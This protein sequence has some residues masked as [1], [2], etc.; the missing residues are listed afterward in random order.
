MEVLDEV[1]S[2]DFYESGGGYRYY[3]AEL[4][5]GLFFTRGTVCGETNIVKGTDFRP[6]SQTGMARHKEQL[7]LLLFNPGKRIPGIPFIG[8]RIDIFDPE[9]ARLYDFRIDLDD[10]E[11]RSCYIFTVRARADLSAFE[12]DAVVIDSMVT[13]FDASTFEVMA[14]TYG[15]SYDA[16]VYDFNVQIEV[17]LT[18]FGDYLV[19]RLMRYIGNWDMVFRKRERGMF[20]ATLFDFNE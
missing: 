14:R 3:T 11:G 18:R 1:V 4:Y 12:R 19:P 20:T 2:G 9:R 13:W 17:Q 16:G 7:K 8:D 15:L 6:R 5:A 10:Y